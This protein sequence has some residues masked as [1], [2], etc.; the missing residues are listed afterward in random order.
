MAR[1]PEPRPTIKAP[2][3]PTDIPTLASVVELPPSDPDYVRYVRACWR[4][5]YSDDQIASCDLF[6]SLKDYPGKFEKVMADVARSEQK[7]VKARDALGIG[8]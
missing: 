1:Q 6:N 7:G 4:W 5:G 3:P 2:E 8:D